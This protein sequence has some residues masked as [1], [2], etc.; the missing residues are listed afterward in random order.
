MKNIATYKIEDLEEGMSEEI[1]KTLERKDIEKF[2]ILTQDFHPLHTSVEYAQ[3]NGFEDIMAHGLLLSS[4]SSAL[5]GMQLPGENAIVISQN[6]KYRK[7]AYP[8]NT[9]QIKGIINKIDK[10]Y[11]RI[12]VGIKI[13]TLES[14]QLIATGNYVVKIR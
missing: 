10:K 13:K 11:A 8:G 2:A 7:P 12:E 3:G 5:I 4:F 6:F 9:F 1:V 14:R